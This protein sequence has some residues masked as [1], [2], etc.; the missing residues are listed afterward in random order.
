[1]DD[2]WYSITMKPEGSDVPTGFTVSA[3][4][5]DEEDTRGVTLVAKSNETAEEV[6]FNVEQTGAKKNK[7]VIE[8]F[9]V[10]YIDGKDITHNS[11]GGVPEDVFVPGRY[12]DIDINFGGVDIYLGEACRP[13]KSTAWGWQPDTIYSTEPKLPFNSF[14]I[15]GRTEKYTSCIDCEPTDDYEMEGT[16][17]ITISQGGFFH[18]IFRLE[19]YTTLNKNGYHIDFTPPLE[20]SPFINTE[21]D[22]DRTIIKVTVEFFYNSIVPACNW[23]NSQFSSSIHMTCD[24]RLDENYAVTE[25]PSSNRNEVTIHLF[26]EDERVELVPTYGTDCYEMTANTYTFTYKVNG[27]DSPTIKNFSFP[28][29]PYTGIYHSDGL[30][31]T[32]NWPEEVPISRAEVIVYYQGAPKYLV[33]SNDSIG[34]ITPRSHDEGEEYRFCAYKCSITVKEKNGN[35]F[36]VRNEQKYNPETP[37]PVKIEFQFD[38]LVSISN[39]VG[40]DVNISDIYPNNGN[41]LSQSSPVQYLSTD[42]NVVTATINGVIDTAELE[43]WSHQLQRENLTDGELEDLFAEME[44]EMANASGIQE[45]EMN[46]NNGD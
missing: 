22:R 12:W 31:T 8:M 39:L 43:S 23:I 14:A 16:V 35:T 38:R 27:A 7:Y 45:M 20:F 46:E 1:M 13:N 10:E 28:V 6:E 41:A 33:P 37:T 32:I 36:T 2:K 40:I 25:E 17:L 4:T 42:N 21:E 26:G 18:E 15:T 11:S 3:D 44:T 34:E 9:H 19:N 5:Y 30:Q 29:E 24:P